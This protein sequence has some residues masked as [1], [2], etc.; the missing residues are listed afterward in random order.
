MKEKFSTAPVLSYPDFEKPFELHTDA[1]GMGLGAMLYQEHDNLKKVISFASRGLSK[2]EKNYPAH[3]LEF[4]ALKWAVVD[5]FHDYLYGN[6]FTVL[7]DNN[8]LTYVLSSA[9][10]DA[11]GHRWLA[12]LGTYDFDIKYR[13]GIHNK[14]ADALSRMP[15]SIDAVKSVC[16]KINIAYIES[17]GVP[18]TVELLQTD[19]QMNVCQDIDWSQ[20]QHEDEEIRPWI[21]RVQSGEKPKKDQFPNSPLLRMF[22]KLCV[23]EGILYRK[24]SLNDQEV[25]QLVLPRVQVPT[26]L[27]LLHDEMGHPGRERT[28]SLIKERFYWPGISA[29][30]EKWVSNCDRCVKRKTQP[31]R[32]P[33]VSI[34][35]TQPLELIC[36]DF[37]SLEQ[38]K[39]G[40][41]NIL[42]VTDH[43]TRFAQAYP[44]RNQT[45]RTTA[46][47]LF[48]HFIVNYGIPKRI[49]SDQGANFEGNLIKELCKILG[50]EKSRTTPYHPMGNGMTERFNRTL[51]NMLG[52][53]GPKQKLNW[54][55]YVSTLVHSYNCTRHESTGQSPYFLMFGRQPNLPIDIAFGL[56][57]EKNRKPQTKY[58]KDLR[59][60]LV[61]A[62]NLAFKV[63]EK[64]RQKQKEQYDRNMRGAVLEVGD[65]VLVRVVHFEGK[66][67][68]ANKWEEEPYIII[69]QPNS[70]IPVYTVRKENGDGKERTLHRNL[71]YPIG[72]I[73][74]NK[75][76][77]LPRQ[78][79]PVVQKHA[80]PSDDGQSIYSEQS[81]DDIVV[82]DL[83]DNIPQNIVNTETQEPAI[84]EN[85]EDISE[86]RSASD[87]TEIVNE[88][89]ESS[90]PEESEEEE[91][92]EDDAN[93]ADVPRR[94]SRVRQKPKW[95]TSGEFITKSNV[96]VQKD[97]TEKADFI[98]NFIQSTRKATISKDTT[99]FVIKYVLNN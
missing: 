27:K 21:D 38:S 2:S 51:F 66:H 39:G 18:E 93:E 86:N 71:L 24:V 9:T 28:T 94:S 36:I 12:A 80:E 79:K 25:K 20:L 74:Y 73:S 97:W 61:E 75:P 14:D 50:T 29:D 30:I 52:T 81:Y 68:L 8:P 47:V 32:A 91:F 95:L 42:V 72:F 90:D 87:E 49:H 55:S 41:Q 88:S 37:L 78:K 11:T 70:Q 15:M 43:F 69:A 76:T 16:N 22:D 17:F 34:T 40:Y 48:N 60:R 44:T 54:K 3:K 77:P 64:S 63:A 53:L 7:T 96:T 56:V 4:L 26:V 23:E 33:L 58:I 5:K 46:E 35:T 59:E 6:T 83:E 67:K 82:T 13:P 99:D 92:E 62:Y 19:L 10:L 1:S 98:L 31:D 85:I 57:K 65:R 45:A 84:S 89:S